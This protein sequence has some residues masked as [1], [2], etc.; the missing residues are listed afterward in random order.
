MTVYEQEWKDLIEKLMLK[1]CM[2]LREVLFVLHL[3]DCE[4]RAIQKGVH[5]TVQTLSAGSL[6]AGIYVHADCQF[7]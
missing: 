3:R 6:R 4:A 1:E 7:S 2:S 5:D